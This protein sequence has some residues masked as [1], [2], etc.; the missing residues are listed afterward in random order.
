[1][2]IRVLCFVIAVLFSL[3]LISAQ[4]TETSPGKNLDIAIMGDKEG[5]LYLSTTNLSGNTTA[6]QQA[7]DNTVQMQQIGEYNTFNAVLRSNTTAVSVFQKGN[8]NTILLNSQALSIEKKVL[9]Q[10]D[11]NTI[12]DFASY[13]RYDVKNEFVQKG[14]NLTINSFGSNSISRD[15]KIIQSG[16][17]ATVL[18]INNS[19]L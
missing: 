9:Q 19:K 17:G 15:L 11:N 14:N 12:Y 6:K 2:K 5:S 18:L 10:G 7:F 4:G 1:M 8:N 13:S 3:Q 16:N